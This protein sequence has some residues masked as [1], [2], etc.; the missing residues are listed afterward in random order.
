LWY[1]RVFSLDEGGSKRVLLHFEAVDYETEVLVNGKAIGRHKGGN[2]P[3]SFDVTSATK[4]GDNDLIV[5][6]LDGTEGFQLHGKQA[7][8][9]R[10]IWY[11]RV[12]GIWQTV[13]L[14]TVPL[15]YFKSLDLVPE[16]VGGELGI[17]L[18]I[19]GEP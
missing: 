18:D 10:G 9:P 7:F 19:S 12:S 11:S 2:T 5:K 13:W 1:R 8:E 3:F 16:I 14:E 17:K 4:K 6:V 15:R